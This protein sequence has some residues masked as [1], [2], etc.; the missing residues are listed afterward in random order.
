MDRRT[1][2][3]TGAGA[4]APLPKSVAKR[5]RM[6]D[7]FILGG[8]S[9]MNGGNRFNSQT[10]A[11]EPGFAWPTYAN[12]S[13]IYV[14]TQPWDANQPNPYP[15]M[16]QPISTTNPGGGTW[17]L[18]VEPIHSNPGCG[19]G[20]GMAMADRWLTLKD[21]DGSRGLKVGLVPCGWS[22]SA[23]NVQWARMLH[24]GTAYGMMVARACAPAVKSWGT[25]RALAWYQGEQNIQDTDI[26]PN[27]NNGLYDLFTKFRLE[28]ENLSLPI[29]NVRVQ[30]GGGIFAQQQG[31]A[32]NVVT[33]TPLITASDTS[34]ISDGIHKTIAA[35]ITLG[36]QLADALA[37][38]T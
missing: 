7:I 9:N 10:G 32:A 22:G 37:A 35:Q 6:N 11:P 36:H 38:I 3:K 18:A 19:V 30:A 34:T 2:L 5:T 31:C 29:L 33:K 20:P 24:Y 1:F 13:R 25:I 16:G 8:Q 4:A 23:L 15:A 26:W 17:Q 28:I 14:Y 12:A 21:P 27:Y